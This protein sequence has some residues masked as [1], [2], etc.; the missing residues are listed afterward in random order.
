VVALGIAN[1]SD[2]KQNEMTYIPQAPMGTGYVAWGADVLPGEAAPDPAEVWERIEETVRRTAPD[3]EVESIRGVAEVYEPHGSTTTYLEP[4]P[5]VQEE[6]CCLSVYGPS[7]VVADDADELAIGGSMAAVVDRTLASGRAVVFTGSVE[8]ESQATLRT[9]TWREGSDRSEVGLDEELQV[10]LVPWRSAGSVPAPAAAILPAALAEELGLDVATV[11][12]RLAGD[13]DEATETRI[14][15]AVQGAVDGT[16]TY[17][18]RGYERP[19][20]A[21]IILLV[22]GV[23]GGVLMLGGTLTATFLALS[24][25]RPD[26]AT[27]SAVGAAPRTRRRVAAAYALVIGFVGAILGAGVGFIPGVAISRPLTSSGHVVGG[28]EAGG[29]FLAIPWL[30]IVAIVLALPLLTAAVVG[31][32]ARSRLPLVARLD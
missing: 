24:D 27:L 14:K 15:E 5:E 26:L 21:V 6:S 8:G 25:A 11:D 3:V 30:L 29:P 19:D 2:E 9:E 7:I 28:P 31:L 1:A 22:L 20:E 10:R 17:V 12:L 23:L 13:L 16:Y 4:P 32:S 18:E